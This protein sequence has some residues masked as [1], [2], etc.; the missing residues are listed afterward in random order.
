MLGLGLMIKKNKQQLV[1]TEEEL[2]KEIDDDSYGNFSSVLIIM[3]TTICIV[4]TGFYV[5]KY[6]FLE[7]PDEEVSIIKAD[8]TPTKVIPEDLGGIDIPNT[9]KKVY[10]NFESKKKAPKEKVN[11]LPPPEPVMDRAQIPERKEEN[12]MKEA[13]PTTGE[14]EPAMEMAANEPKKMVEVGEGDS[15]YVEQDMSEFSKKVLNGEMAEKQK[16]NNIIHDDSETPKITK[17]KKDL[18]AMEEEEIVES[19]EK[20]NDEGQPEV[21]KF[22]K[23]NSSEADEIL[24]PKIVPKNDNMQTKNFKK[25][26]PQV[27]K[28]VDEQKKLILSGYRV[29]LASLKSEASAI[30]AWQDIKAKYPTVVKDYKALVEK[31]ELDGKGLVYRLQIGIFKY[32]SDAR[33]VCK[34]LKEMGQ[35]CFVVK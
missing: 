24:E 33:L 7:Q 15:E 9:D 8:A 28:D 27:E 34:K 21:K 1:L 17:F 6:F 13:K 22:K 16:L 26:V 35:G 5:Y 31:R 23:M 12:Q 20:L 19:T 11:L 10:D 32:E 29:Q 18:D 4:V 2:M 30:N 3:L 14:V 25:N